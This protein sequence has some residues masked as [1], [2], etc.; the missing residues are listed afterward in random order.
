V[1][2]SKFIGFLFPCSSAGQFDEVLKDVV[3]AHPTATHHCY[4]WRIGL[5]PIEEFAQDDGEPPGT[6]GQPILNQ[7]KSA[8]LSNSGLIVVR[9]YGGTN[10]GKGGLIDAY[11]HTADLCIAKASLKTVRATKLYKV[12]YTYNQQN[13]IEKWKNDYQ[14]IEKEAEYLEKVTLILACPVETSS[15]FLNSL[16]NSLHLITFFEELGNGF[17]LR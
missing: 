14:L 2:G 8:G 10:L 9:Y 6:A 13:L 17:E 12:Q 7:L 11:G 5:E 15:N 4:A 16:Q 1:K 3:S